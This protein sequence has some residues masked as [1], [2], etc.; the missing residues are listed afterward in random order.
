M[1]REGPGSEKVQ[2]HQRIKALEK[3]LNCED[4]SLNSFII[5]WTRLPGLQ[6]GL[7]RE[8]MEKQHDFFMTDDQES[9]IGKLLAAVLR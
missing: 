9:Y 5:S 6:W 1:L 4:V 3:R 7:T 2:F 8:E